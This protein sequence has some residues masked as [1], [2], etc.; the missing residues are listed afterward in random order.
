MKIKKLNMRGFSHDMFLVLF[1]V[2]FAIAGVTYLVASHADPCNPGTVSGPIIYPASG[3]VSGSISSC[4]SVHVSCTITGV[5][6][7][8][9]HNALL[10]PRLTITNKGKKSVK[11]T[12][13][14]YLVSY[15][16]GKNGKTKTLGV[17]KHT[18]TLAA[19]HA[20]SQLMKQYRVGYASSTIDHVYYQSVMGK[21]VNRACTSNFIKLPTAPAKTPGGGS[22]SEGGGTAPVS[23]N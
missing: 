2:V 17:N 7:N 12:Y 21:P 14:N 18:V 22:E 23:V 16:T 19:H 4:N 9:K 11:F 13:T 20:T 3:Q 10:Q 1:V 15:G 8:P 6:V 5:P